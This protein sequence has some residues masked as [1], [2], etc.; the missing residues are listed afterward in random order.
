MRQAVIVSERDF[1]MNYIVDH[2]G[3]SACRATRDSDTLG[4][5]PI[6]RGAGYSGSRRRTTVEVD[7][8]EGVVLVD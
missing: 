5:E 3:D 7:W 8:V 4:G 1:I 6:R 2:A